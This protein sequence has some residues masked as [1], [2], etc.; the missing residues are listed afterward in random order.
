MLVQCPWKFLYP[1]DRKHF[2]KEKKRKKDYTNA[3]TYSKLPIQKQEASSKI[4]YCYFRKDFD[5]LGMFR[6]QENGHYITFEGK[7]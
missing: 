3:P 1:Q 4:T 2:T 5:I 7:L 6:A